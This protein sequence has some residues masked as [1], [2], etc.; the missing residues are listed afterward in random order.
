M[1][2]IETCYSEWWVCLLSPLLYG[3]L[4]YIFLKNKLMLYQNQKIV[5]FKVIDGWLIIDNTYMF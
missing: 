4:I 5:F 3:V 1:F 2:W